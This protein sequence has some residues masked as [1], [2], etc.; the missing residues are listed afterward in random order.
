MSINPLC[1]DAAYWGVHVRSGSLLRDFLPDAFRHHLFRDGGSPVTQ[2]NSSQ[3]ASRVTRGP[4]DR[5]Q[6][7]A[8]GS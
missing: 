5:A 4:A 8:A 1:D 7:A 2:V 6:F 3:L